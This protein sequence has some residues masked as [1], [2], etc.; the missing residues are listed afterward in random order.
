MSKKMGEGIVGW[1]D[2]WM[3]EYEWVSLIWTKKNHLVPRDWMVHLQKSLMVA[4][5]NTSKCSTTSLYR[6]GSIVTCKE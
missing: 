2:R 6:I 3:G 1:M 5:K 4:G